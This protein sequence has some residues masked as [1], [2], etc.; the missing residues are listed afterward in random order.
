MSQFLSNVSKGGLVIDQISD[1]EINYDLKF[2]KKG[3]IGDDYGLQMNSKLNSA[4]RLA[5][6]EKDSKD[7][8]YT[9]MDLN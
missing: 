2:L 9:S 1:E 6:P 3:S 4:V 7:P 8:H 5:N